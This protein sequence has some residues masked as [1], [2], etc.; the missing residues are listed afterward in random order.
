MEKIILTDVDGVLLDWD[1]SFD[2]WMKINGFKKYSNEFYDVASRYKITKD[3]S[4]K[5]IRKFNE[6]SEIGFLNPFRDSINYVKKLNNKGYKFHCI[7][8]LSNNIYSQKLREINLKNLFGDCFEKFI[9]LDVSERK[10]KVLKKYKNRGYYWIEDK[11]EN[12]L[13]GLNLGLKSILIEHQYSKK[14]KIENL[15]LVKN[16]KEIYEILI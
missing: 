8:S 2:N 3:K 5:L 6:S 7:T 12:A 16:W 11:L 15:I 4:R 9:F 1:G 13:D 14:I 10:D